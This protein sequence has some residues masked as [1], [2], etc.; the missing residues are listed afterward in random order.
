MEVYTE[1]VLRLQSNRDYIQVLVDYED[2]KNSQIIFDLM[3][4]KSLTIANKG[5]LNMTVFSN[6]YTIILCRLDVK[7]NYY[8][9]PSSDIWMDMLMLMVL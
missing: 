7:L 3:F 1:S 4:W 8:H 6:L 2:L 9:T 5:L